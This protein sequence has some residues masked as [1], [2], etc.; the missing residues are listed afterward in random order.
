M[1][2]RVN[3]FWSAQ[4]LEKRANCK[5]HRWNMLSYTSQMKILIVVEVV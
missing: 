2:P 5:Q 3:V 1:L 4:I